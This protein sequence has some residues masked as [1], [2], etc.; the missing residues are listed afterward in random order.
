M[1]FLKLF[2]KKYGALLPALGL[3][4]FSALLAL[5][6]LWLGGKVKAQVKRSAQDASAIRSLSGRAPSKDQ[7][8]IVQQYMDQLEKEVQAVDTLM[9]Q[10]S[11]RDL[12][13]WRTT[14][15]PEPKETSD[16]IF[17]HFGKDY[18]AAVDRLLEAMN[19]QDA[20]SMA[21]IRSRTGGRTVGG[22]G[23]F[24]ARA[25]SL[26]ADPFVD[27]LCTERAERISVYASPAAFAWYAFWQNFKFEGRTQAV[28]DCWNSQVAFWIY[29]DIAQTIQAMN[30]GST[31]VSTSPVKR[32]LGVRFSGPVPVISSETGSFVG[33]RAAMGGADSAAGSRDEP[34]YILQSALDGGATSGTMSG[35]GMSGATISGVSNFV[36]K[37]WTGRAGNDQID[38]IHFAVSVI[39]DNRSVL[40]FM[41]ELCGQKE[42][43]FREDFKADGQ[44]VQSRHN[45]I[46]I[47]QNAV[48]VVD[49]QSAE[50]QLYRY[51]SGAAVK[52]DLVCEYVLDRRGYDAI[53]PP[54]IKE[55]LGQ[56]DASAGGQ[57]GG[58]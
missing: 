53:K 12:V 56:Q 22:A 42:H 35:G 21:E 24:D 41:K 20:P 9:L 34:N 39:V 6:L 28:A 17:T 1:G 13:S 45:A 57:V 40:A 44:V 19:A 15:F 49:R 31:R 33:G 30:A 27:A 18:I 2:V 26:S 48:S 29:E 36:G 25:A 11:Q 7:P 32:L 37:P 54:V 52:L 51:G 46:T 10:S 43:R 47:L 5:P 14:I 3:L 50:H 38:V 4:V 8:A 23:G 16:L 55:R 58:W